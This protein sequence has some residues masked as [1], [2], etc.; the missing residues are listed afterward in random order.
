MKKLTILSILLMV[1]L[2]SFA[3][4]VTTP[5]ITPTTWSENTKIIVDWTPTDR[6][7]VV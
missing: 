1:A 3:F 2:A 5:T 7:S 4:A 6:K